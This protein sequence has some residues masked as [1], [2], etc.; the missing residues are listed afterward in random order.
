M[1]NNDIENLSDHKCICDGFDGM[2]HKGGWVAADMIKN[3]MNEVIFPA[4]KGNSKKDNSHI[5]KPRPGEII[6][7]NEPYDEKKI[8]KYGIYAGS[9]N[10]IAIFSETG[11]NG[12]IKKT[13]I[14]E[15]LN[16][17]KEYFVIDMEEFKDDI[18]INQECSE[19]LRENKIT[20]DFIND[21]NSLS[22]ANSLTGCET[23]ESS[24]EALFA[25]ALWC[26]AGIT[27]KKEAEYVKGVIDNYKS[28]LEHASEAKIAEE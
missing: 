28:Y 13:D 21:E 7:F 23:T 26:R 3:F 10:V 8:E 24:P 12:T 6:G 19:G 18:E 5:R 1:K 20:L 22:R 25:M 17:R 2:L 15:F 11:V 9:G 16:G 4:G 14:D 27:G